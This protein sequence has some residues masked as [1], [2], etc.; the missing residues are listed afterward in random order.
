MM[1]RI[2]DIVIK[3]LLSIENKVFKAMQDFVPF[4][5]SCF[6]LLGFDILIDSELRPWL[7]EVN[8]SPSLA[9]EKDIDFKIK[10]RLVAEVL[11]LVGLPADLSSR[12]DSS[13][14][15]WNLF[16]YT[17]PEAD[18]KRY[19]LAKDE[20]KK[21]LKI[22]EEIRDEVARC[23]HFKLIFPSYNLSLYRQYFEEDRPLN[24]ILFSE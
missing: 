11:T 6:D 7:L 24:M 23:E 1:M 2:E 8:L 10:T 3:T 13:Q 9:C 19:T 22:I 12:A 15:N 17:S 18:A 4:R 5:N 20:R 16:K 21:D 14:V